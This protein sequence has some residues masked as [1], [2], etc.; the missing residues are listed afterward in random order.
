MAAPPRS[1][2]DPAARG[3]RR[4]LSLVPII[5]VVA[6]LLAAFLIF[7]LTRSQPNYQEEKVDGPDP[8][9]TTT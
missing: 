9:E 3:G 1:P 8:V 5:L 4:R 7:N 2:N 6:A